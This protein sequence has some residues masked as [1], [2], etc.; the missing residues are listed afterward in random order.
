M[1]ARL[2]GGRSRTA[3]TG[4]EDTSTSAGSTNLSAS[5]VRIGQFVKG[6]SVV[7]LP[8]AAHLF[9]LPY[10]I[11]GQHGDHSF[12]QSCSMFEIANIRTISRDS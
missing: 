8:L 3:R 5:S 6:A 4:S 11:G 1:G 7:E 10:G 9:P 12:S 2:N